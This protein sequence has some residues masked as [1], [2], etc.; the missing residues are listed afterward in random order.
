[1]PVQIKALVKDEFGNFYPLFAQA[2]K[3]LFACY[4]PKVT[5]FFIEKVYTPANFIYWLNHNLKTVI[6]AKEKD[7]I[8]G[9]A[10]IDQSYGGVSFC[11]WLAVLPK[12]Q[13]KGVGK[14]LI[15]A[16]EKLAQ[17][18]GCHKLEL[19]SHPFAKTFY[20]K[21]GLLLEGKRQLSYF[22]ID[23]FI[24]GKIISKPNEEN[25]TKYY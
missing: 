17:S 14:K 6:V 7:C 11:R 13:K 1:M 9:F 15:K 16:W 24:F 23:Q 5:N 21:A 2:I 3:T 12:H 4:S 10:V 18:Q 20:E 19:A 25:M 22:G 8:I